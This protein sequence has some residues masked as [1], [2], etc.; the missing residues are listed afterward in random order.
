MSKLWYCRASSLANKSDDGNLIHHGSYSGSILASAAIR[1]HFCASA[2]WN[3]LSSSGVLASGSM[4][5]ASSFS[6]ISLSVS[7][8][9]NAALSLSTTGLGVFAGA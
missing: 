9:R 2:A 8:S 4:P 7:A 1:F 6:D 3:F 5:A